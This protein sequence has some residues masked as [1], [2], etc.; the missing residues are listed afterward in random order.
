MTQTLRW[1]PTTH[2]VDGPHAI[3]VLNSIYLRPVYLGQGF[4]ELKRLHTS[5]ASPRQ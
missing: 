4:A 1:S 2:F 3:A 5:G